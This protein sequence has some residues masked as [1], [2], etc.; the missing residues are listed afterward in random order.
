M[1]VSI[2]LSQP[3]DSSESG[4][5]IHIK[6]KSQAEAPTLPY[7]APVVVLLASAAP[8]D[9]CSQAQ[10]GF[11]SP[12]P[13]LFVGERACATLEVF[14]MTT[15]GEAAA[16]FGADDSAADLFSLSAGAEADL[17]AGHD[18][19][20]AQDLQSATD[21]F[22]S[23]AAEDSAFAIQSE[24]PSQ[25]SYEY[26][27]ADSSWNAHTG[28]YAS[29]NY[30]EPSTYAGAQT[31]AYSQ[32]PVSQGYSSQQVQWGGYE[33]QQYNPPGTSLLRDYTPLL[34]ISSV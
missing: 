3:W 10:F 5:Q 30:P 8:S 32:Q 34:N 29:S 14:Q 33:P 1:R 12:S 17:T 13:S 16:L 4:A 21:L 23:T 7:E 11:Y 15:A 18:P 31:N 2:G 24:A 27:G 26:A 20:T 9:T 22:G 19:F 6:G 25:S 28:Q